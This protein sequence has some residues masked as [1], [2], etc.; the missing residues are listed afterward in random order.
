MVEDQTWRIRA[1][2][3]H[4]LT[5]FAPQSLPALRDLLRH[6]NENVRASAVQALRVLEQE[7]D[8]VEALY[9]FPLDCSCVS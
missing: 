5:A 3:T 1:R 9:S 7:E 6:E 2:A 8:L 4:A